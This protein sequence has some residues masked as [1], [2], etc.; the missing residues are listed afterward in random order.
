M[1]IVP[2]KHIPFP[3]P[4]PIKHEA[5]LSLN[6][7][8]GKC[9]TKQPASNPASQP[10]IKLGVSVRWAALLKDVCGA[11]LW[12]PIERR[13]THSWNDFWPSSVHATVGSTATFWSLP[14]WTQ[15]CFEF[16]PETGNISRNNPNDDLL[17]KERKKR[18]TEKRKST[19]GTKQ[20]KK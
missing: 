6:F 5:I 14:T 7:L 15:K 17:P 4:H 8:E 3:I 1:L 16:T 9:E 19:K 12:H 10:D 2:K 11:L 18:K 13:L 20:N